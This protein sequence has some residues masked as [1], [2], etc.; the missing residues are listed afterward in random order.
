MCCKYKHMFTCILYIC[1][2]KT[3]NMNST[4]T[5]TPKI[6]FKTVNILFLALVA[7][8]VIFAC[9]LLFLNQTQRKRIEFVTPEVHQALLW[10]APAFAAVGVALGWIIFNTKL[11]A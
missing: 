11:K 1:Y 5:V 9:I 4:Q 3:S 10:A 2:A 7:G 8:Q 6:Y